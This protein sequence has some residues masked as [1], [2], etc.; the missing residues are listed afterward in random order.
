MWIAPFNQRRGGKCS[1]DA[2]CG[3]SALGR[4]PT[5]LQSA[6]SGRF[7]CVHKTGDRPGIL[8]LDGGKPHRISH[9]F[10]ICDRT[11]GFTLQAEK[12]L[13]PWEEFP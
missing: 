2:Q 10:T 12:E 13:D 9:H 11:E 8:I 1:R 5:C 7:R 3:M 4:E 6:K